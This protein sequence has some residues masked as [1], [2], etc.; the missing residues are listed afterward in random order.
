MYG[1]AKRAALQAAMVARVDDKTG[2][3]RHAQAQPL[4]PPCDL[5]IFV[6]R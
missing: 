3:K 6:A 2:R 5:R 1:F 4:D